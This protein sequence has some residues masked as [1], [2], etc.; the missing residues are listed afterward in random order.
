MYEYINGDSIVHSTLKSGKG[1]IIK[2]Q[3]KREYHFKSF[4]DTPI[5]LTILLTENPGT[6]QGVFLP[7]VKFYKQYH[8]WEVSDFRPS[9]YP[10]YRLSDF[11]SPNLSTLG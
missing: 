7:L 3:W 4:S 10:I 2:D 6:I 9:L 11:E 1:L 8:S 5:P